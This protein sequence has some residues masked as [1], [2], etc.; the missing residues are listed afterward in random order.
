MF[1]YIK[2]IYYLCNIKIKK[3]LIGEQPHKKTYRYET[4]QHLFNFQRKRLVLEKI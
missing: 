4:Q 1:C 2:K 3:L